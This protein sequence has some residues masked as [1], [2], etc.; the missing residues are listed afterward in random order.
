MAKKIASLRG[1]YSRYM[2]KAKLA[3]AAG[4]ASVFQKVAHRILSVI[5]ALMKKM[6]NLSN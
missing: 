4:Q 3:K 1:L 5:D 2:Q 6:Q